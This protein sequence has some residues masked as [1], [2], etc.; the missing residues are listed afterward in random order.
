VIR[1]HSL[2]LE[3]GGNIKIQTERLPSN[4]HVKVQNLTTTLL[5]PKKNKIATVEYTEEKITE[6][7]AVI[8]KYQTAFMVWHPIS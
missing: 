6:L 4:R 8:N 3:E 5:N 1:A 7:I 2:T